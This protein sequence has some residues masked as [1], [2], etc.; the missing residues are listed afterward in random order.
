MWDQAGFPGRPTSEASSQHECATHCPAAPSPL[1]EGQPPWVSSDDLASAPQVVI[2]VFSRHLAQVCIASLGCPL[3]VPLER[4]GVLGRGYKNVGE[5]SVCS[6]RWGQC[7]GLSGLSRVDE[8]K[9]QV[10][11]CLV[12]QKV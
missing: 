3:L 2:W 1:S 12:F 5:D 4:A 9:R 7:P 10:V 6:Q 11:L 8:G